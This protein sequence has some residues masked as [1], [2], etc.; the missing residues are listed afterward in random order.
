MQYR[1]VHVIATNRISRINIDHVYQLSGVNSESIEE[2][3][4]VLVERLTD[5]SDSW[6]YAINQ[7]GASG[8]FDHL[9]NVDD[10]P[11]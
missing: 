10:C 11:F 1:D 8:Q 9:M 7:I 5:D 6:D 2:K 4:K 3:A